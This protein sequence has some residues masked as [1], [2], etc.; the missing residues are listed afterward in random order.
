MAG[1]GSL[2]ADC[3]LSHGQLGE[4][5]GPA[6]SLKR[7]TDSVAMLFPGNARFVNCRLSSLSRSA[8]PPL[9]GGHTVGD[10]LYFL[11]A[12]K[13]FDSGNKLTHGAL[14]T[15]MGPAPVGRADSLSMLFPGNTKNVTC[16]IANLSHAPCRSIEGTSSGDLL[17]MVILAMDLGEYRRALDMVDEV[18][19]RS[20]DPPAMVLLL[21]TQACSHLDMPERTAREATACLTHTDLDEEEFNSPFS[22]A[23]FR[24]QC[25]S[26]RAGAL[27][28]LGQWRRALDDLAHI[29]AASRDASTLLVEPLAYLKKSQ[30]AYLLLLSC[31]VK[32]TETPS[33][34]IQAVQACAA[35]LASALADISEAI[36]DTLLERTPN[37][38]TAPMLDICAIQEVALAQGVDTLDAAVEGCPESQPM[39]RAHLLHCRGHAQTLLGGV[40]AVEG[41]DDY[42][43]EW[44][45]AALGDFSAV[46]EMPPSAV[47]K[48]CRASPLLGSIVCQLALRD[49][50]SA[51]EALRQLR[52]LGLLE[53]STRGSG[54]A[55]LTAN[56]RQFLAEEEHAAEKKAAANA[57]QLI[58]EEER[59]KGGRRAAAEGPKSKKKGKAGKKAAKKGGGAARGAPS[60][61]PAGAGAGPAP[62]QGGGGG[63]DSS[64]SEDDEACGAAEARRRSLP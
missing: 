46:L 28:E 4:V 36:G 29:P 37:G 30:E 25:R 23:E 21:R 48:P 43:V 57:A 26:L 55:Y 31:F 45:E 17:S 58:R 42:A 5:V 49:R 52:A 62:P 27:A 38:G 34:D 11:G 47:S 15:V 20:D 50:A 24:V 39:A 56:V 3:S 64:E 59:A 2:T 13:A 53:A 14:G 35:M 7:A 40:W 1:H 16:T 18:V 19:S 8:P 22:A 61:P 9:P 51:R 33:E 41:D 44:F 12:D 63:D 6:S 54:Y 60:R 32:T 10:S